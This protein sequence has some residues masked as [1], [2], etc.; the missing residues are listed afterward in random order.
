MIDAG[1]DVNAE[2]SS[3]SINI[4]NVQG[5]VTASTSSGDVIVRAAQGGVRVGTV[6]GTVQL[7]ASKGRADINTTSGAIIIR[8]LDS[9][10]VF[11]KTTSGEVSFDGAVHQ[12]GRYSFESLTGQIIIK[13]PAQSGF[14][15][16]AK[17]YSGSITT[18]FPVQVTPGTVAGERVMRGAVA[19]G[20]AEVNATS[21]SGTIFIVKK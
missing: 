3:D 7:G 15:L 8:D 9:R 17:T 1:G 4:Q 2:N 6:S 12:D 11:A 5:R 19:G 21:Y 10:E 18:Q 14:N 20:G 13:V 16:S